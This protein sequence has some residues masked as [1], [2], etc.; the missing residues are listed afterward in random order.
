MLLFTEQ[1]S[2]IITTDMFSKKYYL[3]CPS[4]NNIQDNIYHSMANNESRIVFLFLDW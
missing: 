2:A 1:S 3:F 4:F